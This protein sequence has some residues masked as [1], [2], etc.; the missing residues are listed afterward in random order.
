MTDQSEFNSRAALCRLLAQREPANQTF[1][2]G[3]SGKL[4]TPFEGEA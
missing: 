4:V 1:L 3:G 2:D